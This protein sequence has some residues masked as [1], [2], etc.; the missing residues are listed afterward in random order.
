MFFCSTPP[1]IISFLIT[2][3]AAL[4]C[5][6]LIPGSR[7]RVAQTATL[8]FP[9]PT[10]PRDVR[11]LLRPINP[12]CRRPSSPAAA[13][14]SPAASSEIQQ[15]AGCMRT[16]LQTRWPKDNGGNALQRP[17]YTA[18]CVAWR[19]TRRQMKAQAGE[20]EITGSG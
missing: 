15:F 14:R 8:C 7:S 10:L 3:F 12:N 6:T 1:A 20:A 17:I 18:D 19:I 5:S 16:R 9:S 2:A 11:C 4:P 13:A